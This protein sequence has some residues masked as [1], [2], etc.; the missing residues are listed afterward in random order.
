[1]LAPSL[2][3]EDVVVLDNLAAH[4]VA[5]VAQTIRTA[6]ASVLYLPPYSP[7]LNPIEELCA[8]L[9]ALLRRAATGTREAL[10]DTI[11][12]VLEEFAPDECQLYITNSGYELVIAESSPASML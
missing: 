9:E 1:M 7:H 12:A 8:K 11:N 5:G 3:P 10:G 6:D 4:T 2:E